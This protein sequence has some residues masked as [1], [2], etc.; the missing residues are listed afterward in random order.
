MRHKIGICRQCGQSL[1]ANGCWRF[2]ES[3]KMVYSIDLKGTG[4][5]Y[6]CPYC[7]DIGWID[8]GDGAWFVCPYCGEKYM[9][10]GYDETYIDI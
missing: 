8:G 1:Y 10:G 6:R 7:R 4:L 3:S 2:T 5:I 9:S